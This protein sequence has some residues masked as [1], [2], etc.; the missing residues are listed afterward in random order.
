[1][2]DKKIRIGLKDWDYTC[3]DGC[4]Y[5]WGC[6]IVINGTEVDSVLFSSSSEMITGIKTVLNHLGYEVETYYIDE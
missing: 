6:S 3:G 4:C 1:M 2:Y 5:E